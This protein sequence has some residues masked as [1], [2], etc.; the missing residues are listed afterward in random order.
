MQRHSW[1]SRG[2]WLCGVLPALLLAA[3]AHAGE[4]PEGRRVHVGPMELEVELDPIQLS[5]YWIGLA[6]QTLPDQKRQELNLEG[7]EGI[8]VVDVLKESPADEAGFQVGDV[9]L[10]ANEKPLRRV[11]NLVEVVDLTK[12]DKE[13]TVELIR[14]DQPLTIKVTPARRPDEFRP[15]R[16]S[17]LRERRL[18]EVIRDYYDWLLPGGRF[19]V[20]H[21]G[22][23]LPPEA[24]TPRPFA[25]SL[26]S[27]MTVVITKEGD[28]PAKIKVTKDDEQWE[29]TEE[30]LEELRAEVR[31]HVERMVGR[32]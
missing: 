24:W 23:I 14:G 25:S 28:Q 13:V 29:I 7:D 5:D 10:K 11:P 1:I 12:D 2:G 9:L 6:C 19:R 3:A 21:P 22:T 26:P 16:S 27:N 31:E 8:L 30:E 15:P 32:T 4:P 18:P 17:L 20:L